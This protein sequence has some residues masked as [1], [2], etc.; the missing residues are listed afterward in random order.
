MKI[1]VLTN[2][3]QAYSKEHKYDYRILPGGGYINYAGILNQLDLSQY[4][5]VFMDTPAK[6]SSLL[7]T[8]SVL[9]WKQEVSQPNEKIYVH[10]KNNLLFTTDL[11]SAAQNKFFNRTLAQYNLALK[12]NHWQLLKDV[13]NSLEFSLIDQAGKL[14]CDEILR[15]ANMLY[16]NL[17][18]KND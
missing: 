17:E 2:E 7:L 10:N 6:I 12:R 13:S 1:L 9:E 16:I 14:L 8:N 18:K 15:K 5:A 3:Y 4:D 11:E